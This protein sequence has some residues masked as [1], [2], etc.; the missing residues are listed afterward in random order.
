MLKLSLS[1]VLF[2]YIDGD[3]ESFPPKYSLKTQKQKCCYKLSFLKQLVKNRWKKNPIVFTAFGGKFLPNFE[4]LGL[5]GVLLKKI[6]L[7]LLNMVDKIFSIILNTF[8]VYSNSLALMKKNMFQLM[9]VC[10]VCSMQPICSNSKISTKPAILALF[11]SSAH[12]D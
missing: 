12:S 10:F 11:L 7:K 6:P 8:V 3:K 4:V 2:Y 1:K 9:I 5:Q